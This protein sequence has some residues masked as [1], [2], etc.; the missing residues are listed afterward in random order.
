MSKLIVNSLTIIDSFKEVANK[1]EFDKDSNLIVSDNNSVGKSS[2]IKSIY[3]CLGADI[4]NF[5]PTW[6]YE[7]YIFQLEIEIDNQACIIKRKGKIFIVKDGESLEEFG[8]SKDFSI[9]F[10]GRL[11]M[12]LLLQR[13]TSETY[14]LSYMDAVLSPFYIDQDNS[15][16]GTLFKNSIS[17]LGGYK[18]AVKTIFEYYLGLS[19]IGLIA[20]KEEKNK[21]TLK[22]Q[23]LKEKIGQLSGVIEAYHQKNDVE[24]APVVDLE[25]LQNE[26]QEYII[27]TNVL[28]GEIGKY[29]Q[30]ISVHKR[31]LD[32]KQQDV[33]ELRKLLSITTKAYGEIEYICSHCQSVLTREKS[34]SR[35][36]LKDNEVSIKERIE[37]LNFGITEIRKKVSDAED[38]LVELRSQFQNY[39]KK[40]SEIR[41]VN[42]IESYVNQKVLS[43][44]DDLRIE[45]DIERDKVVNINKEISKEIRELKKKLEINQENINNQ[46]NSL[47]HNL[48][49]MLMIP[50]LLSRSFGKFT[51]LQGGGVQ[52]N[53]ECLALFLVYEK[54]LS[55]NSVFKLP[56]A[57]DS[58]IK[59][60]TDA[61][62]NDYMFSAVENYFMNNENQTF[63]AVIRKNL[64]YF[65]QDFIS[66]TNVLLLEKPILLPEKYQELSVQLINK[67]D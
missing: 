13:P 53:K 17:G 39:N 7:K 24:K 36:E 55:K 14:T 34:L 41:N 27:A 56:M 20:K 19:N 29:S 44:L 9:W 46:F 33:K 3:Y 10:Q 40:I 64:E 59:N 11:G 42:K 28:S 57:M 50:S 2:I 54:L 58:F 65:S 45:L 16:D 1:F 23:E 22:S 35:L 47:I 26:L 60:E 21:N 51:K 67:L 63:F 4:K 49:R 62:N 43:E 52:L 6:E 61:K 5:Q 66:K 15:W 8:N 32:L 12:N 37:E 38:R 25:G 18:D 30:N 48:S 31:E